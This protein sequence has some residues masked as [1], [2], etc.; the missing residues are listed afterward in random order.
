[1]MENTNEMMDMELANEA[2]TDLIETTAESSSGIGI[3]GFLLRTGITIGVW[4]G[5][6]RIGKW[7]V[8]QVAGLITKAEESKR[9]KEAKKLEDDE[10]TV[11][12]DV[13]DIEETH[14]IG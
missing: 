12:G 4:E 1:M 10:V 11:T 14:P 5:G 9:I 8:K 13:E 7:T 2:T 6:K 3:L